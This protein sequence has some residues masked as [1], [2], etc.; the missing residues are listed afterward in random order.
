MLSSINVYF[1]LT[2]MYFC[3]FQ[4]VISSKMTYLNP[5]G[6]R[7]SEPR[8]VHFAETDSAYDSI[9]KEEEE[10][11][12]NN[13]AG[14]GVQFLQQQGGAVARPTYMEQQRQRL[15]YRSA[16][17]PR[18]PEELHIQVKLMI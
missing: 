9:D 1:N 8:K 12:Q 18:T 3:I 11:Q 13:P 7:S 2:Y 6:T 4:T 14:G 15:L 17:A 16:G 5:D 10:Q